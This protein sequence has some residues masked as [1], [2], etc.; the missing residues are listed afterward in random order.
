[1]EKFEIVKTA[2]LIDYHLSQLASALTNES[3][4]RR[5]VS[6]EVEWRDITYMLTAHLCGLEQG[7][8]RKQTRKKGANDR[9]NLPD[10]NPLMSEPKEEGSLLTLVTPSNMDGERK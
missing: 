7:G 2:H 6:I 5:I 1:M 4:K 3:L 10:R 8:S 9:S